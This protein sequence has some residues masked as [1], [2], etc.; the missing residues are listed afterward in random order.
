MTRSSCCLLLA[1]A[2]PVA[3]VAFSV[4]AAA[5]DVARRSP[6]RRRPEVHASLP[7]PA[8]RDAPLGSR[9]PGEDRSTVSSDTQCAETLSRSVKAWRVLD[10]R[11]D[12]S[13]TFEHMVESVDM[14]QQLTGRD[15]VRYNSQTDAKAPLGFEDVARSV[16]TP[17]SVVTMDARGKILHREHKQG[18]A[19]ADNEGYM[20]IPLPEEA[21]PVGHAWSFLHDIY[22]PL[23][24]GT[25]MKIKA[26]QSFQLDDVKTG[27]ATIKVENQILTP[28]DDPNR[29]AAAPTPV[30]RHGPLRHRRRPGPLPTDGDRQASRRL[31]RRSQQ[32]PLPHQFQ[33]TPAARSVPNRRPR[34]AETPLTALLD[35]GDSSPLSLWHSGE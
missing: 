4:A 18:K 22:V 29:I 34:I 15:E 12:G 21:V 17:L 24:N 35:C 31:P 9:T 13:A 30:D 19:A 6:E 16:G 26:R 25:T 28:V 5:D 2:L 23:N 14:R 11:P 8:R 1:A 20:T 10:V 27:V 32:H 33:R 3:L 7:L